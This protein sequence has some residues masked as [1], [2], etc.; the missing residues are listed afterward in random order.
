MGDG[1]ANFTDESL[2]VPISFVGTPSET[3]ES[4]RFLLSGPRQHVAYQ[5]SE[6]R[7]GIITCGGLCPGLNDVIRG[8]V[9]CLWRRYEV[10]KI[11]GFRYGYFGLT[12]L[13]V[14]EHPPLALTPESV[15]SIHRLGGSVLG[16]S[17]GA[18]DLNELIE[19]IQTYQL[20]QLYCIGGDGTMRGATA[21]ARAL[22]ARNVEV[23]VVGV[24]KTIDNDIPYVERTFGFDT[25][26]A[27]SVEAVRAARAEASSGLRGVGLVKL[28]GR[29]AG[30]I[31]ANTAISSREVDVVL[32]PEMPFTLGELSADVDAPEVGLLPYIRDVLKERGEAVIVVAEGVGQGQ[33]H[34]PSLSATR[35]YDASGNSKLGDVG[36]ALKRHLK[37]A[38]TAA[39]EPINLKYI[40]PS[41]MIRATP[42]SSADAI[43][44][45][46]LA[47]DAVHAAMA[48]FTETL[49]GLWGGVGVLVPF[50][51]LQRHEKRINLD[52]ALWRN[53]L[54]ATGQP[55]S[56]QSSRE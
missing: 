2:S 49:I 27:I 28:M 43:Y 34:Q 4:E 47:E 56:L 7:A 40:D 31:A 23:S 46:Q 32:V 14:K 37:S 19:T 35:G 52:G 45:G 53:V 15:R 30:F 39:G 22:K 12:A 13:G 48:G 29:H 3:S 6:V 9:N 21:L 17:R 55:S 5:A 42:V 24:P 36:L 50:S 16:S 8:V 25:A 33:G 1:I 11:F 44:C 41:Y 51:C 26:I 10:R 20:N 54:D 18:P 38:F